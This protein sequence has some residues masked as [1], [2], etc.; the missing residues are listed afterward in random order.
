MEEFIGSWKSKMAN[1]SKLII[2]L[3]SKGTDDKPVF[4]LWQKSNPTQLDCV[5]LSDQAEKTQVVVGW[6]LRF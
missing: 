4:S 1:I 2:T 5:L 3:I 6:F